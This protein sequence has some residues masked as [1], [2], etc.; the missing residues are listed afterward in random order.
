MKRSAYLRTSEYEEAVRSLEWATLQ[1]RGIATDPYLWKWVVIALHNATQGFMVLALCNG[2]GFLA[3]KPRSFDKWLE[4]H[5]NGKTFP[6]DE[7][8]KFLSLYAKVKNKDNFHLVGAEPFLP[9]ASSDRSLKLLNS[10]RNNFIHF[11]PKGWSL[12]LAG[13]PQVALD[14]LN[15]IQFLGWQTSA[16]IWDRRD[17]RVRAKRALRSLRTILIS[18]QKTNDILS[19]A[20]A[21]STRFRRYEIKCSK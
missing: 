4:A 18:E 14:A 11:T 15:L 20:E 3:L 17:H 1:A 21:S 7:L 19:T 10:I 16:I 6:I 8:D 13:L 5:E 9:S 12:E 2:N